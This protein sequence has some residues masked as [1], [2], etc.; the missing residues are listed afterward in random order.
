LVQASTRIHAQTAVKLSAVFSETDAPDLVGLAD[1][2]T[3]DHGDSPLSP[4]VSLFSQ[5]KSAK[6][7]KFYPFGLLIYIKVNPKKM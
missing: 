1:I 5:S 4:N 7:P 3:K 2:S 6:N